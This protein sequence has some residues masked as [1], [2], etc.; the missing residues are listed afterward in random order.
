MAAAQ[1]K[2]NEGLA[3]TERRV[4]GMQ[5]EEGGGGAMPN[6]GALADLHGSIANMGKSRKKN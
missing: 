6:F 3:N 2:M 4:S 1:K 5:Q